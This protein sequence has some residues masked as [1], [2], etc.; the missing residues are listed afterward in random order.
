M[1]LTFLNG[2]FQYEEWWLYLAWTISIRQVARQH[3]KHL[4]TRGI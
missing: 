4:Q 3:G 1:V 2:V